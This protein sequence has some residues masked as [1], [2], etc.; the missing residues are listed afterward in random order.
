MTVMVTRSERYGKTVLIAST[1]ALT[2]SANVAELFTLPSTF[3]DCLVEKFNLQLVSIQTPVAQP[4]QRS[5]M[6]R[7]VE[8]TTKD[9]ASFDRWSKF[10][11]AAL[12]ATF[13]APADENR[14]VAWYQ[15]ETLEV[16]F[17]AE[18]TGAGNTSVG[19]LIAVVRRL[20]NT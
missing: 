20:R 8:A 18:D 2:S 15:T 13:N 1:A 7:L 12:H 16:S 4:E 3:G 19:Q 6:W 14:L 5:P 10:S 11:S 17:A 9:A